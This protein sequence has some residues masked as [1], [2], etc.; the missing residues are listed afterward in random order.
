MRDVDLDHEYYEIEGESFWKTNQEVKSDTNRSSR[1]GSRKWTIE[2]IIRLA[3]ANKNHMSVL[4]ALYVHRRLTISQ[5]QR[6]AQLDMKMNSV[7]NMFKTLYERNLVQRE[8][9]HEIASTFGEAFVY[10]YSLSSLGL[11]IVASTFMDVIFYKDDPTLPK[12]HYL[13]DDLKVNQHK[14]HFDTQ[15]FV[16]LVIDGLRS[17]NVVT[18]HCEWRRYPFF[19]DE[20]KV[21][22]RPDWVFF[23][24]GQYYTSMVKEGREWEN[25][26]HIP[27]QTRDNLDH[28]ILAEHYKPFISIECDGKT[29]S[30]EALKKKW[31]NIKQSIQHIP[32]TFAVFTN[33]GRL[34]K[35]NVLL[36]ND[37]KHTIRVKTVRRSILDVLQNELAKD[38]MRIIQADEYNARDGVLHTFKTCGDLGSYVDVKILKENIVKRYGKGMVAFVSEDEIRLLVDNGHLP[39]TVDLMYE[40]TEGTS[41]KYFAIVYARKAWVNPHAKVM[42]LSEWAREKN[43][44]IQL[45][46]L[47]PDQDELYEEIPYCIDHGQLY[48]TLSDMKEAGLVFGW[49]HTV[50]R[51]GDA[52][53]EVAL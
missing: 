24:P 10:H 19:D 8:K 48:I 34:R 53:E 11:Q 26:L 50:G 28:K 39:C 23:K 45:L 20:G 51:R 14:H 36:R 4:C 13:V 22:Y 49:K 31:V 21:G 12:Q 44:A 7:M 40:V 3:S 35:D 17:S 43:E 33:M 47:F 32:N 42:S 29:A 25:P 37:R 2:K 46:M 38:E 15:E 16:S 41:K 27:L 5:F 9:I 30:Y 52:W 18:A 1:I 6:I